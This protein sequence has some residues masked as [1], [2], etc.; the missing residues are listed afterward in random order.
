MAYETQAVVRED[1]SEPPPNESPVDI[2]DCAEDAVGDSLSHCPQLRC[3]APVF[4]CSR[5]RRLNLRCQVDQHYQRFNKNAKIQELQKE[6]QQL[7]QSSQQRP[8]GTASILSPDPILSAPASTPSMPLAEWSF[9]P[10]DPIGRGRSPLE[11]DDLLTER[12]DK[13]PTVDEQDSHLL[14]FSLLN[15][16]DRS[17]PPPDRDRATLERSIDTVRLSPDQIDHL[18]EQYF[19][20]YHKYVEI[21][22]PT[23]SPDRYY[24]ESPLLFW[25]VIAISAR[26]Y[27]EDLSLLSSLSASVTGLMWSV[28][29]VRPH[30]LE[31]I[32]ALVLQITW[33]LPTSSPFT[34]N[35]Y[36][37]SGIAIQAAMQL[38]LHQPEI[39][40]D[41][42][43]TKSVL[44][45]QEIH[46]RINVWAACNIAAQTTATSLGYQPIRPFDWLV[47]RCCQANTIY[48]PSE[49]LR[50]SL[51]IQ[52][53][54]NKIETLISNNV[55]RIPTDQ[56][57]HNQC[58]LIS[59][60]EGD[61][62]E[63]NTQL[64]HEISADNEVYITGVR[65]QL[66]LL[67]FFEQVGGRLRREGLLAAFSSALDV[68]SKI[69]EADS[70]SDLL[71]FAP[72]QIYHLLNLA[73]FTITKLLNSGLAQYLD[74]EEGKRSFN[75]AV[76]CL[77]RASV[78][79]N[80]VPGRST[81]VLTKLWRGVEGAS[82]TA[83]G[84]EPV[85]RIRS[86]GS[87]S[88]LHDETWRFREQYFGQANAY[89]TPSV[90]GS[91]ANHSASEMNIGCIDVDLGWSW[92]FDIGT[93][94][95]K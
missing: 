67:W 59:M 95:D 66:G 73:C 5:C 6:L 83:H 17:Q 81:E 44:S 10:R 29:A 41:F 16:D 61:L 26:R 40:Q 65:L 94:Q 62:D 39:I 84:E 25:T 75:S 82:S 8:S 1:Q 20:R 2:S 12:P 52:R 47:D 15:A 18:F 53:F 54:S 19:F 74:F 72:A 36:I 51:M 50:H 63:L 37:L 69:S 58:T 48:S 78:A 93:A 3:D 79:N 28:I 32:Q 33:P 71:S 46:E 42:S 11:K 60:L 56:R 86:R 80:D 92:G 30:S 57:G 91:E 22:D 35:I 38:G 9:T 68:I 31:T 77:R 14:D 21:L 7:R 24:Q 89:P 43:R 90:G 45:Q 27:A 88:V 76:A 4:P 87:A 23:A 55:M 85:L 13:Q 64:R 70:T 34:E 49:R